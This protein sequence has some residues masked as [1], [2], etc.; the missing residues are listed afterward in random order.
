MSKTSNSKTKL[1]ANLLIKIS[2]ALTLSFFLFLN[3][4]AFQVDYLKEATIII[5]VFCLVIS[6][7]LNIYTVLF[8]DTSSKELSAW[9]VITFINLLLLVFV[10]LLSTWT[11]NSW[12]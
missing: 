12:I 1:T 2:F 3:V 10:Y 8:F 9:F 11:S 6:F 4:Q 5:G 7:L